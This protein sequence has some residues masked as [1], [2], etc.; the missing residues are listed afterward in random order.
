MPTGHAF[1]DQCW[2]SSSDAALAF[3]A[4]Q[5]PQ[6]Q[7]LGGCSVVA[8]AT[9]NG[10]SVTVSHVVIAGSCTAP[11][12]VAFAPT[13]PSCDVM[14]W[15]RGTLAMS[16]ADGAIVSGAIVTLW[17]AAWGWRTVYRLLRGNETE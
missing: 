7:S 6:V 5:F 11:A 2:L 10:A 17:L 8:S 15:E 12:D 9:T 4:D 13:F 3:A 1:R 16:Y 14:T